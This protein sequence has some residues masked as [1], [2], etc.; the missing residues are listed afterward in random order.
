MAAYHDRVKE[1]LGQHYAEAAG[2][3]VDKPSSRLSRGE[4][5]QKNFFILKIDLVGSTR[6]LMGRRPATYLKL[7][8]TY[9][10]TVDR[11]CQDYGADPLQTEY[12]GDSVLAYFP[13]T[14][15]AEDVLEAACYSRAA[16]KG[17]K[18][19]DTT[20]SSLDLKCKV[21]L[22]F[23]PLVVS[24]IGPRASSVLTAI[25]YELHRVAKIEKDLSTGVGRATEQ[26]FQKVSRQNKKFFFPVYVETP[27]P[28]PPPITPATNLLLG[29][30]APQT[31]QNGEI[32]LASILRPA[33][34][35]GA[36]TPLG[37]GTVLGS[38]PP[39]ESVRTDRT[40]IG[41]NLIWPQLFRA[42]QILHAL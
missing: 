32:T 33:S 13:D 41:Y 30:V 12:A 16:V 6:L 2:G 20:L 26:F 37:L 28:V 9:L 18:E 7:A 31:A 27:T 14:A 29:H 8:H 36:M 1:I 11:I 23:A 40:L 15:S 5:T 17:I 42:L 25:G 3:L 4:G 38:V 22:H 24:K 10:S 19:L 35:P 21:V 34:L 39:F